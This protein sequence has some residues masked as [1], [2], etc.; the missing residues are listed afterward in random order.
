[1]RRLSC[2]IG[3]MLATLLMMA[4]KSDD[5]LQPEG[6]TGDG[7]P[8]LEI[9]VDGDFYMDTRSET[10]A[11]SS[12]YKLVSSEAIQHIES[13]YAYIFKGSGEDAT[14]VFVKKLPWETASQPQGAATLNYS[15]KGVGLDQY[16]AEDM[17]VLVIAVDNRSDT[18]DFP[19]PDI[20][21]HDSQGMIGKELKE[22][23]LQLAEKAT[24]TDGGAETVAEK[25]YRMANTEVFSG[26]KAFKASDQVIRVEMM[27]CVA[28]VLCYLTDIPYYVNGQEDD[29]NV[30]Q[31]IELRLGGGLNLNTSYSSFY[32]N[33][34]EGATT[35][36]H[37]EK[38][39]PDGN[40]I[41][42]VNISEYIYGI[43][44]RDGVL[45]KQAGTSGGET[46]LYVPEQNNGVVKTLENTILF[47]AYLLP[48]Q[49]KQ[50][51]SEQDATL[52]LV[53]KNKNV[54]G[55]EL[56]Y[57]VKNTTSGSQYA[58]SLDP[59]CIYS[60][61]SKPSSTDTESDRPASL[62]GKELNLEVVEWGGA[63]NDDDVLF[64]PYAL[65]SYISSSWNENYENYIFDCIN[66]TEVFQVKL[67]QTDAEGL[68]DGN[69]QLA[70]FEANA[71]GQTQPATWANL[72]FAGQTD[73]DWEDVLDLNNVPTNALE[74]NIINVEIRLHDYVVEN[75][76]MGDETL[77]LADKIE[78]LSN[79]FR[80]ANLTLSKGAEALS[81]VP[82]RQFNAI[83]V[84][85]IDDDEKE[86]KDNSGSV[87]KR[88]FRR[89]DLEDTMKDSGK[90]AGEGRFG[91][92]G[93][94]TKGGQLVFSNDIYMFSYGNDSN[95][96]GEINYESIDRNNESYSTSVIWIG[97]CNAIELNENS[98]GSSTYWSGHYWYVP[99]KFELN[100][101]F[102]KVVDPIY[103]FYQLSFLPVINVYVG[104]S[105]NKK[106]YWSSSIPL[107]DYPG[108]NT[109]VMH[110]GDQK[111]TGKRRYE[112]AYCRQ[113]RKF[114]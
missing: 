54:E 59:N 92:W 63:D 105:N 94:N 98:S 47:G 24:G 83:T 64:P 101:F 18:Y 41:A 85:V 68:K 99:A 93:Y 10:G 95:D 12:G 113:A 46:L 104:D 11:A 43:G 14:C 86:V 34:T 112:N 106:Y 53:L 6:G 38:T 67:S 30:I 65:N 102:K 16:G 81:S 9:S 110:C 77:S 3:C 26:Y 7:E 61:G 23:K 52:Q 109:Y 51:D 87:I 75:D 36:V 37:A 70:M 58:Y 19:Y 13:M 56:T 80:T 62:K 5:P 66:T 60:I 39:L 78:K 31:S 76:I 97:G 103:N 40:V 69:L 27:R 96:D 89:L 35:L 90:A 48:I 57:Y 107:L 45:D 91:T 108:R 84:P 33:Y 15:L 4:C 49:A 1:M 17:Q 114:Q 28:G 100:G 20:E 73:D 71:D 88:G 72:R 2:Y 21:G 22:V 79:D 32:K 44:V 82:V 25:A 111:P 42:S 8:V 29:R 74:G 55:G 50:A